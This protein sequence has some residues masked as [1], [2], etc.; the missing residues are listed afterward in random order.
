[1]SPEAKVTISVKELLEALRGIERW[2]RAVRAVVETLPKD[3]KMTVAD[4]PKVQPMKIG[5]DCPPP[6]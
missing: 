5:K 1:M 2:V 4:P 3:T 6:E